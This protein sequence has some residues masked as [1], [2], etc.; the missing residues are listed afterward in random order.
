MT[1]NSYG[2]S[3][4]SA[5]NPASYPPPPAYEPDPYAYPVESPAAPARSRRRLRLRGPGGILTAVAVA[6]AVVGG[7]TSYGLQQLGG[8]DGG[9]T[10]TTVSGTTVSESSKGTVAG[11]ASAVSPAVVEI[12]ATS[13]AGQ[14][15]G[16]GVVITSNGE[17]VTNNHVI[18]GAQQIKVAL[19]NGK[20]YTAEV[21]GTDSSKD[22]ALIKLKNASGLK[23]ATLGNSDN[24]QV[25]DNVVA[26][27]SPEGLSGTVTSGIVSALDRDVTVAKESGGSQSQSQ[28]QSQGQGQ[29]GQGFG[30][31]GDDS[32]PFQF[33]GEQFNGDTG[34]STTTYKAIQTDASLNPGN[35]GGALIDMNGAIVGINSA[36]YSAASSGGQS[37]SS[38]AGSVG[39]GFA[40]PVNTVK[41]DLAKL[42]SGAQD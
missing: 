42:R 28:G 3:T 33:G 5:A 7:A 24:L 17:I 16:A 29:Q 4:P 20:S 21:V 37:S 35:S 39:L 38:D 1:E 19:K 27:G 6:A 15:T 36:M 23:A 8:G 22:L 18:S 14:S 30:S 25:G 40:I 10:V 12:S 26:I 31:G 41:A 9:N 2:P 34:D 13:N 11:V 32:W